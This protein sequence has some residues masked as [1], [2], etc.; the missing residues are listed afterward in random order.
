M[1]FVPH[2]SFLS[3]TLPSRIRNTLFPTSP[4]IFRRQSVIYSEVYL[5]KHVCLTSVWQLNEWT[6]EWTMYFIDFSRHP[7]Y[8]NP[9][10]RNAAN[11]ACACK[12]LRMRTRNNNMSSVIFG[13][14][15][16]ASCTRM[17]ATA[18]ISSSHRLSF[19]IER[20]SRCLWISGPRSLKRCWVV[21]QQRA[22]VH[23][24]AVSSFTLVIDTR[25]SRHWCVQRT[26]RKTKTC[27]SLICLAI[28]D[29]FIE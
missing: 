13:I 7:F 3:F 26:R 22:R 24:I 15:L 10:Q 1:T 18:H 8:R 14:R 25:V 20:H 17:H 23:S 28:F 11:G 27:I 19:R 6:I 9:C 16:L 4:S 21:D 12:H 29:M 5:L 2:F